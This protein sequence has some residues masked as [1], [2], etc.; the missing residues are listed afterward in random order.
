MWGHCAVRYSI[1]WIFGAVWA[2]G[3]VGAVGADRQTDRQTDMINLEQA[4]SDE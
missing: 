4:P 3:A 2:V 1:C